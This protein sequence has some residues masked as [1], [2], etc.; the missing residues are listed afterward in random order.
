MPT[1]SSGEVEDQAL[2]HRQGIA[3]LPAAS[4]DRSDKRVRKNFKSC[5][6]GENVVP[7]PTSSS[8]IGR[9]SNIAGEQPAWC[10]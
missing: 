1:K 8:D 6:I 3:S 9:Q 5:P 2:P 10:F 7:L 4:L